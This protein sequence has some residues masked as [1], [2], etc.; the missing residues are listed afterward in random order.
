MLHTE[1][2]LILQNVEAKTL[3]NNNSLF[4][5]QSICNPPSKWKNNIVTKY[6]YEI[7]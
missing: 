1:F 3:K 7:L 5:I 6:M 4:N 2:E